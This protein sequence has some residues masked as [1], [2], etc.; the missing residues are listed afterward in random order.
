MRVF[1]TITTGYK[2]R[3][4]LLDL[5][6][7]S[8][9]GLI[10]ASDTELGQ[11]HPEIG[12]DWILCLERCQDIQDNWSVASKVI[13]FPIDEEDYHLTNKGLYS[14][15]KEKGY[16]GAEC[17]VMVTGRRESGPAYAVVLI[18]Q[19]FSKKEGD[20]TMSEAKKEAAPKENLNMLVDGVKGTVV[21]SAGLG[22][23]ATKKAWGLLSDIVGMSKAAGVAVK[24]HR[25]EQ[26]ANKDRK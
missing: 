12:S 5:T 11:R 22:I 15:M 16:H 21:G 25:A 18:T 19:W 2:G 14:F 23:T 6:T 1:V 9:L 7:N 3:D 4:D 8:V 13:D 10:F 24:E 26:K 17:E 20:K